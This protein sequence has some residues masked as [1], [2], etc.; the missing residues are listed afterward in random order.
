MIFTFLFGQ[1]LDACF[2]ADSLLQEKLIA[3]SHLL[4][5]EALLPLTI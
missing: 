5:Q 1:L 4:T 2:L 3:K